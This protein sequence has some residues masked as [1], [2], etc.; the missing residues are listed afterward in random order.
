VLMLVL[1]IEEESSMSTI[2]T[3]IPSKAFSVAPA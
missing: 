2:T 1:V 3:T